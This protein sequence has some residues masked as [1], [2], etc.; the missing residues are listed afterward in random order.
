MVTI[1]TKFISMVRIGFLS[2]LI[3]QTVFLLFL[4][5][6]KKE[7]VSKK[8]REFS[9]PVQTGKIIFKDVTNQ[10]RAV[11]NIRAEQ[12]V[13]IN[14]E[15]EGLITRV[16]VEEGD[17]VEIGDLLARIDSRGYK[18]EVEELEAEMSA[19]KEEFKKA[20]E[21]LRPEEKEKLLARVRVNESALDL[22][23][24]EQNRFQK[25]VTD[26]VTAQ[27]ILDEVNDRVRQTKEKL[28]ESNAAF[29]AAKQSRQEDIEQLRA[30]GKGI[31]KRLEKAQLD[32]SK[33]L[34][35]APF[36]GTV[37]HKNIEEGAFVKVG[38]PVLEMVSSSRLKAVLE[39][40]QSYRNKLNKLKG[41]DFWVKELGLKFKQRG[42][43]RVIPDADIYSGNIRIQVELR[44]PNRALFPGLTL[45]GMMNFGVRKHVMHVPSVALVIS[46]KGTVVYVVKESKAHLI[47]VRAYKEQNE[48]VEID[49]FTHQLSPDSELILRGSGAVFP[50]AKVFPTNLKPETGTAFSVA[51]NKKAKETKPDQPET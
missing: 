49:D 11:G 30:E 8:K 50:G 33:T 48:L 44:R 1:I 15:V 13:T 10:V 16:R 17:E 39:L 2:V 36:K 24:K 25:L 35:Y 41:I 20:I 40:P 37:I 29:E 21:G 3:L 38:S 46:E 7:E 5:C 32:F 31:I 42:K 45:V 22:A 14:A 43:L 27:S 26:G 19:A 9:L 12:R 6:S 47:P 34:I 51:P 4:G 23:I 28:R 18:L